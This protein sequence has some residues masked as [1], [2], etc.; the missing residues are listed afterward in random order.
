M[1][2][3]IWDFHG[4]DNLDFGLLR[5]DTIQSCSFL[6]TCRLHHRG[7]KIQIYINQLPFILEKLQKLI[8]SIKRRNEVTDNYYAYRNFIRIVSAGPSWKDCFVILKTI[9]YHYFI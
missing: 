9:F 2:H 4:S 5:Y 3:E 1:N 7:K 8:T 6:G